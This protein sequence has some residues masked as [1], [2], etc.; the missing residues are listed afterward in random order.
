MIRPPAMSAVR[1]DAGLAA[2]A[3]A[4]VTAEVLTKRL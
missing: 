1:I 3:A 2:L 4:G